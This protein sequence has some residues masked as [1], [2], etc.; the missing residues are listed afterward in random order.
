MSAPASAMAPAEEV[1]MTHRQKIEALI[2]LLLGM[3]VAFLS[4]TVVSNALPTIITDLHGTQDQYT[5]VITATLLA[6]TATTPIWGKFA[7]LVSKKLLVQGALFLFTLGSVLAGLSTSVD[8]LIGF[9]VIQGL[10]LGGLQALVVI[11]VA[12]M[13]SP[14][15]RGRYQGPMAA[16]MSVATVAGPLIGGVIVDTSWLG[17]R[18]TFYVCVPLAV[19][20]LLVIQR[21]LNVPVVRK[22][23]SIDYL[24]AAL[25]ASGVSTL[26]IWVTLAGKNFDWASLT[27]YGLVALGVVLLALAIFV[28]SKVS[29]PIIPLHIF[30]DRTTTLA[31]LASVGV[32]VAL[33][34]G[35]VFLGQ[36][37]Q[38]AR[39]YSPTAAGLLTLP[40]VIGSMLSATVSG[41]LITRYGR[42]KRFLVAGAAMMTIGFGLLATI[43]AHTDMVVV[44]VFLFILG[45]G[46][47]MTMQNLV[48]AVQNNVSP[49]NLGAATSTV[50]FFRSLGGAAGVSVLGAVLSNHVTDLIAKGLGALGIGAGA[51]SGGSAGLA[52]LNEL[53][54]PIA[55]IVRGAYGDGTARVFLVAAVMAA[56]SFIAIVFIKEVALKT[57]SSDEERR[58]QEAAVADVAVPAAVAPS[59]VGP[60]ADDAIAGE[61]RTGDATRAR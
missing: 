18:W 57:M 3:F 61:T 10:G 60:V 47:G 7:D 37:F 5:W 59:A 29:S 54:A 55:A 20:A 56:L 8:M 48:L 31:T 38:I 9:R 35:A 52:N 30:R 33:F 58:A 13:F 53:P 34:G 51:S 2:G 50:T 28:E 46:M 41:N 36:Y 6:S 17:W 19:I 39:G 44:G 43:D 23:V 42:W 16:V 4:S 22:K 25:I 24:G 32:G 40:M 45:C 1:P 11:V 49:D 26:L 14:R 21:T 27:S 12:T 15:E